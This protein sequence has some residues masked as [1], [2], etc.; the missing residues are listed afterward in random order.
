[1]KNLTTIL[2]DLDATL[3]DFKSSSKNAIISLCQKQGFIPTE[4]QLVVYRIVNQ[5][6]W[7]E[8]E[9]GKLSIPQIY[10]QRFKLWAEK[11]NLPLNCDNFDEAYQL[12]MGTKPVV[13]DEALNVVKALKESGFKQ[14]IV[15]NGNILQQKNKI[16][17]SGFEELMDGVFI[18]DEIGFHKP[19]KEFFEQC[20]KFI[21]DYSPN[22]TVIVGDSLS[23]DMAGGNNAGIKCIWFNE[24]S[25]KSQSERYIKHL[26]NYSDNSVFVDFEIVSLT[27]IT[28]ILC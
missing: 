27:E 1:M 7:D 28:G 18:S 3:I 6:L 22:T 25:E 9:K 24:K 13:Y 8:Y 17:Y 23:S 14:Y 12:E 15:T 19:E 2:W 16:H 10:E 5:S 26:V 11:E 20:A 4:E 21:P